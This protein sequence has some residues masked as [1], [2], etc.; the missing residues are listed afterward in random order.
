MKV[1][2]S[3]VETPS[4]T[5]IAYSFPISETIVFKKSSFIS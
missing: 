2:Q 5:K 1:S 4:E 3:P